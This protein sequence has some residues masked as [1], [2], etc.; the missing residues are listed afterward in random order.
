MKKIS[1]FYL[2]ALFTLSSV[3]SSLGEENNNLPDEPSPAS[4]N[5]AA[6]S[7]TAE[8]SA[9][10]L[11]KKS[12]NPL[13]DL[14]LLWIQY[15]ATRFKG[16]LLN[17][18][19]WLHSIKFQ[20]VMSFPIFNGDWNFIMRP[21]IQYNSVPLKKEAGSLLNASQEQIFNDTALANIARNPFGRTT[22]FGDTGLLTIVGPNKLDGDVSGFGLTQILPTAEEDVLGQGMWQAGPAFL[23]VHIAPE[24]GK[25]LKS[26]NYGFLAQ[27]WWSYAGDHDRSD[28][29]QSDLQYFINYRLTDTKMIGMSPN[30]RIDWNG[31]SNNRY[32]IPVGLG[33]TDILMLGKL[34]IRF[35]V[36]AQ[37]YLHQPDTMG[38]EWNFRIIVAPIIPQFF[39]LRQ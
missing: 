13:S 5:E 7:V 21:V 8:I 25:G 1:E 28:T 18:D 26:L 36:E 11:A 37:Y 4:L 3:C 17:D 10:E 2:I 27:H 38:S 19:E 30:I 16:D 14:W 34:P 24:A 32:S 33:Y 29:N 12:I 15:D 22:G 35:G 39:G 23:W 20:P 9:A 31:D 6:E